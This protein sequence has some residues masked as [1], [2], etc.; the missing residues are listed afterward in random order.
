MILSPLNIFPIFVDKD[1]HFIQEARIVAGTLTA[2]HHLNPH[3][4][5]R[6]KLA[7]WWG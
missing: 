2:Q 3:F 7:D 4:A 1:S 6:K 5:L